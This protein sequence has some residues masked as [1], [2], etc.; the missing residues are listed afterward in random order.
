[1]L[2]G[3]TGRHKLEVGACA[4]DAHTPGQHASRTAGAELTRS[5]V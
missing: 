2:A 3:I 1:M 5:A 4:S